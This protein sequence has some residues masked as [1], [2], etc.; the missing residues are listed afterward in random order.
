MEENE[1][2][3]TYGELTRIPCVYEKTLTN[4]RACCR[5]ANHFWL[6]DREGYSCLDQESSEKC[7]YLLSKIRE[8]SSFVLKLRDI[9]GPLPHNMELRVQVGGLQGLQRQAGMSAV[10]PIDIHSLLT[11]AVEQFGSIDNFPFS[12]M[13]QSVV[14]FQGRKRRTSS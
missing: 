3:S 14:Q 12:E 6:A 8:K 13:M 10:L 4:N 1:Y 11:R 9:Q 7:A 5:M 2:R